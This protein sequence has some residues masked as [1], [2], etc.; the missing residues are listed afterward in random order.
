MLYREINVWKRLLDGRILRYRCF[1]LLPSGGYCVQSAD[2]CDA[3]S[4]GANQAYCDQQFAELLIEEAPENRSGVYPSLL[5]AIAAHD[6]EF[7]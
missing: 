5:E 3:K 1:E 6:R 2:F 7:S 4:A